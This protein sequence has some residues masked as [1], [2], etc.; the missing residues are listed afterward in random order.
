MSPAAKRAGVFG[1]EADAIVVAVRRE[2]QP[3]RCGH[4]DAPVDIAQRPR[5]AL[6]FIAGHADRAER[7]QRP[8]LQVAH[9]EAGAV[10]VRR[11]QQVQRGGRVA[12]LDD[13]VAARAEGRA[14]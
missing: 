1:K 6:I 5:L 12:E 13:Q 3:A 14:G 2:M 10:H 9:A 7:I 8:R 4:A 11:D